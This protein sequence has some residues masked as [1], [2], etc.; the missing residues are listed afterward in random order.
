MSSEIDFAARKHPARFKYTT[1]SVVVVAALIVTTGIASRVHAKST[2]AAAAAELAIP[3]VAAHVPVRSGA[4]QPLELPGRLEAFVNAAIYARVPGYLK[5]WYAD[6]GASV[7]QGQLLAVIDTP[8]LDQQFQQARADLRNAVANEQLAETTARRWKQ[9]LD[10]DSVSKQ[11][12]DEK[13]ADL[14]AKRANVAA[15]EAN[16]RR[17]EALE[18]FKRITAPFD[19]TVTAR[20]TDVGALIDTGADQGRELFTVSDS[21]RLRLYVNVPQ[22]LATSIKPGMTVTLTVPER[23]GKT[24]SATLTSTDGSIASSSGTLLAQLLVDNAAGELLPG[25]YASVRFS[26]PS[27]ANAMRIPASAL[28]FRKA[29]LQV[30]VVGSDDRV[31]LKPVTVAT[32]F[33][34]Q[35]EIASGLDAQDRVIDNP[36]DSLASG[37][38][39]QLATKEERAHV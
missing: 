22:Q 30:A 13:C 6:I 10:T 28:I 35:V 27:D 21:R 15:N 20:R 16:V 36:P 9:L 31:T 2:L 4:A 39:V 34:S 3:T 29:G 25:E 7:K 37:D 11:E 33:G 19:G 17:L 23:P 24:F 8:E 38:R 32:D 14:V 12:A 18:S 1:I 5:T 26:L